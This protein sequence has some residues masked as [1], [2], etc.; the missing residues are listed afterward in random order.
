MNVQI[1]PYLQVMFRVSFVVMVRTLFW[2]LRVG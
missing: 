2:I 1:D